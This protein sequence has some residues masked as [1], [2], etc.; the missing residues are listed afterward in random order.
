MEIIK[1]KQFKAH[2]LLNLLYKNFIFFCLTKNGHT[3]TLCQ[4]VTYIQ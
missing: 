4:E 1:L 3:T 2:T